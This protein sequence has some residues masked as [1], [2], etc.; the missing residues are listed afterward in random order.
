M[1]EEREDLV[2]PSLEPCTYQASLAFDERRLAGILCQRFSLPFDLYSLAN[3]WFF[4][5]AF[6]LAKYSDFFNFTRLNCSSV[7]HGG[8]LL[9]GRAG[10]FGMKASQ[11]LI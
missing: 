5:L 7:D 9:L 8:R 6:R 2:G 10:F 1:L 4:P 11:N 3:W